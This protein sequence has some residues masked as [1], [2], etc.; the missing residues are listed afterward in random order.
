[1]AEPDRVNWPPKYA[2]ENAPVHVRNEMTMAAPAD[3]VWAWLIR[4]P[5]WPTW[6]PN[7]AG[8][9]LAA[10]AGPDLALGTRFHWRTFGASLD[11]TVREFV[12]GERIAWDAQGVGA[13]VYH[14]WVLRRTPEG[15]YVL[16]EETQHGWLARLGNL[17]LPNRMHEGHQVWL[18]ALQRQAAQGFPGPVGAIR[19]PPLR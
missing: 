10:G 9:Q 18:E 19:E 6:Y 14:A 12:P 13:D 5:L 7:S 1:M 3:A 15:C 17:F 11:S 8:V 4:A 16:T 2:P